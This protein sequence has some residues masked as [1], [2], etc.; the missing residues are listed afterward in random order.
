MIKLIGYCLE[1]ELK[2]LCYFY[3]YICNGTLF[4]Y[5]NGQIEEF[6]LTWDMH[7]RIATEVER[8]FFYL[9]SAAASTPIYHHDIKSTNIL[10]HDK[11][12]GKVADFRTSRSIDVDETHLTMLTN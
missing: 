7:L 3:E 8:A 6:P 5:V 12:K 9:Y 1:T 11:Y 4:Q 10:L 2:F